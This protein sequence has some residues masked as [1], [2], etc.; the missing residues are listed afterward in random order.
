LLDF[1]AFIFETDFMTKIY[2]IQHE[3]TISFRQKK[4][5]III[6]MSQRPPVKRVAWILP[7]YAVKDRGTK[8]P[9]RC[10]WNRVV[11]CI[12]TGCCAPDHKHNDCELTFAC[13][14]GLRPEIQT[15]PLTERYGHCSAPG[16]ENPII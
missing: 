14:S 5:C 15:I 2:Q 11:V 16:L 10:G 9:N 1:K 4:N 12:P 3:L 13:I 8:C 6:I 7:P